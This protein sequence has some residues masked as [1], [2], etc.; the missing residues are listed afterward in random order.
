MKLVPIPLKKYKDYRLDV[1]FNC[2][3]WDPQFLDNNTIAKYALVLTEKEHEELKKLTEDVDKENGEAF[4]MAVS[5]QITSD[6]E[7]FKCEI[8]ETLTHW[9]VETNRDDKTV[10]FINREYNH[11]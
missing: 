3:K 4:L 8:E 9:P 11:E 5:D 1:I 7:A 6:A 10:V 2:Y